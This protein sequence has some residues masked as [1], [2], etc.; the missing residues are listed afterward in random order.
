[1]R[2]VKGDKLR[3]RKGQLEIGQ[4]YEAATNEFITHCRVTG[5]QDLVVSVFMGPNLITCSVD[6]FDFIERPSPKP[7]QKYRSIDDE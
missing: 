5:K 1:M 3:C 6:N 7:V 4:Y 2:I